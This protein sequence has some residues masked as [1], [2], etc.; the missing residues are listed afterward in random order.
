M[1]CMRGRHAF[2]DQLVAN[3]PSLMDVAVDPSF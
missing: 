1:P 2:M 3:G